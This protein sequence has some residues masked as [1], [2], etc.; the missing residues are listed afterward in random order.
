MKLLDANLLLYAVNRDAPL[1]A[2]A[3]AWLET[4]LSGRETV[5]FVVQR[6][7]QALRGL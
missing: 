4:T 6:M 3:K 5:D 7:E 1:H 2:K